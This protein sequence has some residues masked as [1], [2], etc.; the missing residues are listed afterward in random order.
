MAQ[1]KQLGRFTIAGEIGSGGMGQVFEANDERLRRRVALKALKSSLREDRNAKL[2]FIEEARVTGQ[3]EHPGI[4]PIYAL[5]QSE[6][7]DPYFCMRLMSGRTLDRILD[8]WHAGDAEIRRRHSLPRLIAMFERVI[9]TIAYAHSRGVIHRDIKPGNVMLGEHGEVWVLDWGLALVIGQPG[10]ENR[11]VT[12]RDE[13]K[14]GLTTSGLVVGSPGFMSPEQ[15]GG[16]PADERSDVFSLGATLYAIL[17]GLAPVPGEDAKQILRASRAGVHRPLRQTPGGRAA[18]AALVAI[19]ERCLRANPDERYKNANELLADVRGYLEDRPVAAL[20]EDLADH[21][22]RFARRNGPAVAAAALVLIILLG[23]TVVMSMRVAREETRALAAAHEAEREGERARLADLARQRVTDATAEAARRRYEAFPA[24]DHGMDLIRRGQRL[25]EAIEAL[26]HAVEV[27]PTFVEAQFAVG[28][29]LRQAGRPGPAA[30]AYLRVDAMS[31]AT[32]GQRHLQALLAAGFALDGAGDYVRSAEAF[33]AAAAEAED[34][35][36]AMVGRAICLTYARDLSEALPLVDR[37]LA[38]AGYLWEAHYGRGWLLGEMIGAGLL[39]PE[40]WRATAISELRAA[41]ELS[42]RQGEVMVTLARA[43]E[44]SELAGDHAEAERLIERAVA[45]EPTNGNRYVNRAIWRIDRGDLAVDDDLSL[46]RDHGANEALLLQVAIALHSA[47]GEFDAA[48]AALTK[49]AEHHAGWPGTQAQRLIFA[50]DVG[51]GDEFTDEVE[52][53]AANHP[54]MPETWIMRAMLA[55]AR[56]DRI[57]AQT[58]LDI[59]LGLAPT[60]ARLLELRAVVRSAAGDWDDALADI[61]AACAV[62]PRWFNLAR[63]RIIALDHVGRRREA[64]ALI[65]RMGD[66][67]P[68]R[69]ED[70]ARFRGERAAYLEP[71]AGPEGDGIRHDLF[72]AP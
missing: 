9:E 60:N 22:R 40:P 58:A 1:T 69:G 36:L 29:A 50:I 72:H 16:L 5:E 15:A 65:E 42:P 26:K 68:G 33:A 31:R 49:I 4:V 46:A 24:Y 38:R 20:H 55:N 62:Q 3:L 18:P 56:G 23:G 14:P 19:A 11:V 6:Q 25:D 2:R 37:A 8:A 7:G 41:I 64:D 51:R 54:R 66:L 47:R 17:A 10:A 32:D 39:P 27:D 48:Y 28:E 52:R 67:F 57:G 43:L 13:I 35:P 12:V 70:I 71:Q 21:A 53:F 63:G 61:E 45:L 44:A 59:G 34:D 30:E